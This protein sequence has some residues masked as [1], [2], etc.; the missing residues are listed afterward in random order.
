[1]SKVVVRAVFRILTGVILPDYV[2]HAVELSSVLTG[3]TL[4][5]YVNHVVQSIDVGMHEECTI[6][7]PA[8][9]ASIP[10]TL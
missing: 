3:V 8:P 2:N 7:V 4:S 9:A 10:H 6:H 5:G 1:M